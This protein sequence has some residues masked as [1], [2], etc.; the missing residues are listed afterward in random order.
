MNSTRLLSALAA[1]ALGSALQT[2]PVRA[3]TPAPR[4]PVV[5][6]IKTPPG[7]MKYDRPVISATPGTKLR[8]IF[9]N[10]DEMPHNLVLCR[11]L[12]G[13]PSDKGLE[14]AQQAW[15]MGAEGM[16]KNWIPDSPRVLAH[17]GL[18]P[19]HQ[20]EELFLTVPEE[21][22]VYPYVCT[23]P[24]HA[25]VMNGELRV[26][27]QGPALTDLNFKL[28]LGEWD[29]L[30]DFSTLTPHRAGPLPDKLVDI[31]LEGMTEHFGVRYEG[32]FEVPQDGRYEFF[33]SS[34]DGSRL[35]I[36]GRPILDNDGI[37]PAS[38]VKSR[39]LRLTKGPHRLML[40]YFEANGEEQL[41]LAWSGKQFSETPLSKWIHPSRDDGGGAE[42]PGDP[43]T[44]IPLG[45]RNG[46][47]VIYRNFI[48]GSSPR[49]IAVGY[50]N[51][52]NLCF[53][54][55][56]MAPALFWRGAFMD[57][58]R[59]WTDRG[60]GAQPPLGYDV[61]SPAADGPALAVLA[62]PNAAWPAK[63]PRA[64]GIRFRGYTLD[65]KRC[66]TFKYDIGCVS[67]E[68]RYEPVGDIK[69]GDGALVR[70]LTFTCP[71]TAPGLYLRAAA[72][73]LQPHDGGVWA[74]QGFQVKVIKGSPIT[75]GHSGTELLVPVEFENN[76]ASVALLYRWN[77]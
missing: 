17:T 1:A 29:K 36:D 15:Q 31:K 46:E 70:H 37:H 34:D 42:A 69:N 56:Q 54:A 51:G 11:P 60:S 9:E 40:D 20:K 59:H 21:P 30:P 45:P 49:G 62:D 35:S 58:K 43:N 67:V 41:Y 55:D 44:G 47:A 61:F 8:L 65:A 66:P 33:L 16:A 26:L 48:A 38:T 28:Y 50:P 68:E 76:R 53:D 18:V 32:A 5:I 57:A 39:N 10:L 23:F 25:M 2:V 71:E 27:T 73:N 22:G 24:G 77:S 64:E 6:T 14:V 63:K 7:Q 74:G 72:G 13:K 19:A 12:E 3:Q 52:T 75:R 4:E